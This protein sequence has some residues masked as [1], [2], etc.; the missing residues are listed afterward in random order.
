MLNIWLPLASSQHPSRAT[1]RDIFKRGTHESDRDSGA[2]DSHSC[3]NRTCKEGLMGWK[4]WDQW[5]N[6]WRNHEH[7]PDPKPKPVPVPPPKP[8]PAP[9]P[10][11]KPVPTPPPPVPTPTPAP[12]PAPVPTPVPVPTPTP[13]PPAPSGTYPSGLTPPAV[14]AGYTRGIFED[15]LSV[16][17]DYTVFGE[18]A[19]EGVSY[20]SQN[21]YYATS[22]AVQKGDS[23]L[24][25]QMYPDPVGGG[26]ANGWG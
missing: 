1:P 6:Q 26:V 23:L 22:H 16:G 14:P 25:L 19:Y 15:F 3:S 17:I 21:G 9:A 2:G 11:P 24:R 5:R 20:S 4:Q 13:P 10:K 7:K 18:P 12:Q 8:T